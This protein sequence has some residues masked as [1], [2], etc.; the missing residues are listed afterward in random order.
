QHPNG[1]EL[2]PDLRSSVQA[3]GPTKQK[4]GPPDGGPPFCFAS[5]RGDVQRNA[6]A[7]RGR[8][9]RLLDVATLRARRLEPDDLV[10]RSLEVLVELLLRERGLPDDEVHVGVLVD[11]ELDL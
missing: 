7:E 5:E 8:H 6:G 9:R 10:E 2:A 11:T 4:G 1:A 3:T